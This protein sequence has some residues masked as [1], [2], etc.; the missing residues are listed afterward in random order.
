MRP[1]TQG[2]QRKAF[3]SSQ[4]TFNSTMNAPAYTVKNNF[5]SS[6]GEFEKR[7]IKKESI[8]PSD[9]S[10]LSKSPK[11]NAG[12]SIKNIKS[13]MT[14]RQILSLNRQSI[15][16]MQRRLDSHKSNC[17]IYSARNSAREE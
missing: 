7:V 5:C 14:G 16:Y 8:K 17:S 6:E 13:Q 11:P 10:D 15:K 3:I 4:K 1:V 9:A 12:T 2:N